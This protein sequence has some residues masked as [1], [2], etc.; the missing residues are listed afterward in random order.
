[1]LCAPL[2]GIM[3]NAHAVP[4]AHQSLNTQ[5]PMIFKHPTKAFESPERRRTHSYFQFPLISLLLLIFASAANAAGSFI[6][7]GASGFPV[8]NTSRIS[9]DGSLVSVSVAVEER[10]GAR[11]ETLRISRWS[12]GSGTSNLDILKERSDSRSNFTYYHGTG[13][14]ADGSVIVGYKEFFYLQKAALRWDSRDGVRD[15]GKLGGSGA[16]AVAVSDDGSVVVGNS[17]YQTSSREHAFRWSSGEGMIDIGTLGGDASYAY[18]VSADG[19]VIVGDARIPT[20]ARRAFRWVRGASDGVVGNPQMTDL[21]SLGG[22]FSYAMDVS[23]DGAVVVGGSYTKYDNYEHAFLWTD[24]KGMED[25]GTFFGGCQ[26]VAT[27]VSGD[28]LVVAGR[29]TPLWAKHRAFR[30]TRAEGMQTVE[31]WL[32]NSGVVV[33]DGWKLTTVTAI[34]HDG[35]ILVGDGINPKGVDDVWYA[36]V[37]P[38]STR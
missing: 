33:P 26:S 21:G 29:S 31:G 1:M 9:N 23:A 20:G 37:N 15:I 11:Y 8:R 3:P 4:K 12:E 25:L 16:K 7:L 6:G 30:W 35:S 5:P 24:N 18:A 27:R 28:G 32:V 10:E 2:S 36:R 34:N 17:R 22:S 14:S 13:I 19:S 38:S